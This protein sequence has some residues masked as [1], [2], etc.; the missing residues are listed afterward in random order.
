MQPV[1]VF[2]SNSQG[3]HGEGAAGLAMR[4]NKANRKSPSYI[5]WRHDKT[6][7]AAMN[8]PIGSI[9]RVGPK[10]IFGQARGLQQGTEGY[11]YA[12][13]TVTRPGH[14]RSISRREIYAQLVQLWDFAKQHPELNFA[15]SNIGTGY[16]GWTHEE[17]QEVYDF[18]IKKHGRPANVNWI[19]AQSVQYS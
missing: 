1:F 11:G 7:R 3:F 14:K 12:I 13:V 4:G 5:P 9:E 19:T 17:M 15:M 18:L 16:A 6:F 10:A 8:A 2:G